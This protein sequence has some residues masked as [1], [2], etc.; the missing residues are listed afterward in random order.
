MFVNDNDV[1]QKIFFKQ[2]IKNSKKNKDGE[3]KKQKIWAIIIKR[4]RQN[5][6][7]KHN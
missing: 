1:F 3:L 5:D 7:P 6:Q 4:F 2:I